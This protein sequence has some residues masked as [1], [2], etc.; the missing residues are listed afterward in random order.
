[1]RPSRA[2]WWLYFIA[3]S[4]LGYLTLQIYTYIWGLE[5]IGF[6]SYYSNG[7]MLVRRVSPEGPGARA[8]LRAGDRIVAVDGNAIRGEK[9]KLHFRSLP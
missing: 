1:M 3:A 7:S 8:G 5:W 4:F 9:R 2:P 6:G